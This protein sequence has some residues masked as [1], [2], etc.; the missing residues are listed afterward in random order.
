MSCTYQFNPPM[1][2][3]DYKGTTQPVLVNYETQTGCP[4]FPLT[5]QG[6]FQP[7]WTNG[8]VLGTVDSNP[9]LNVPV[10]CQPNPGPARMDS[11]LIYGGDQIQTFTIVQDAKPPSPPSWN[12][13]INSYNAFI[14]GWLLRFWWVL[15]GPPPS[16]GNRDLLRQIQIAQMAAQM[17]AKADNP[18]AA[19]LLLEASNLIAKDVLKKVGPVP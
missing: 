10:T 3:L 11:I 4:Y 13:L 14:T 15:P 18:K 8:F 19:K 9:Q 12:A 1:I 7:W 5:H 6:D 2:H 17:S 16:F